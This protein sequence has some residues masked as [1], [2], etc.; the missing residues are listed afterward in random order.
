MPDQAPV[1]ISVL[2]RSLAR[3]LR[4]IHSYL[5][6]IQ[7]TADPIPSVIA[8]TQTLLLVL[9][10]KLYAVGSTGA[11]EEQTLNSMKNLER[12]YHSARRL[13]K[14]S[15]DI[16][17]EPSVQNRGILGT[18]WDECCE[19]LLALVYPVSQTLFSLSDMAS[20]W[21]PVAVPTAGQV[22]EGESDAGADTG[23]RGDTRGKE[24]G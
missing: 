17:N 9:R 5:Y 23:M 12:F 7:D 6:N 18:Q 4:T 11:E 3:T 10:E 1:D 19:N 13:E 20:G 15:D 14:I 2:A 21:S 22:R 24:A 16:A 8:S